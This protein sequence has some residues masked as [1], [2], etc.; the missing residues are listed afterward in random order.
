[1]NYYKLGQKV[2]CIVNFKVNNILTDP[3]AVTCKVM[4]PSKQ[5]DTYVFG[6]NGELV[7]DSTGIY[8]LDV[9]VDEKKQWN[10]RFEGTGVCTAVEEISFGVQSAFP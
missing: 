9:V 7:K 2:R 5:I 6:T 3:T 8:H 4:N 1:M 10:V